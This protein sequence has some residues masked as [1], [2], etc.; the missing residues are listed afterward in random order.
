MTWSVFMHSVFFILFAN[1][2]C[3]LQFGLVFIPPLHQQL[4]WLMDEF[5]RQCLQCVQKEITLSRRSVHILYLNK[6]IKLLPCTAFFKNISLVT[7][8][9]WVKSLKSDPCYFCC[10]WW[11]GAPGSRSFRTCIHG[12]VEKVYKKPRAATEMSSGPHVGSADRPREQ[13]CSLSRLWV[14]S[15]DYW[16]RGKLHV[17]LRE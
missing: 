11:E 7:C 10:S 16:E 5:W 9:L 14:P 13:Q 2:T 8:C 1:N 17:A 6:T 4:T 3:M 12:L 15:A